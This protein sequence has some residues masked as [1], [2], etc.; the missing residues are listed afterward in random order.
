M[1]GLVDIHAHLLSGIDDGPEDLEGALDMAR[2]AVA[3]GISTIA[4]TPHLRSDFPDVHVE[5]IA[6]RCSQLAETLRAEEVP[7]ELEPGAEVSLVWA[8]EAGEEALKMATFG[9]RGRDLLV[10]T[11]GQVTMLGPLLYQLRSRG[12]RITLAHPERSFDFQRDPS[13]LEQ[14]VQDGLLLQVN[15]MSLLAPRRSGVRQL[16]ER[17]CRDGLAHAIASDGHRGHD[18]RPVT[19]LAEGLEALTALVGHER[20]A[21]MTRAA[22]AAIL[23][24]EPLPPRLPAV[25]P[26]PGRRRFFRRRS[27]R[28]GGPAGRPLS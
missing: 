2:A 21:W 27:N 4:V 5:E 15:A 6:E 19:A 18:W 24:G 11:P 8:L 26:P 9:Q 16:S 13:R 28:G 17:M 14:L 23:R 22:P 7:L 10:E 3:A 12:L 1:D 25:E 20:A